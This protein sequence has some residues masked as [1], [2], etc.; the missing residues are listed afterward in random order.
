MRGSPRP[1]PAVGGA[2]DGALEH[3]P[4]ERDVVRHHG[5]RE[6]VVH[7]LAGLE[8]GIELVVAILG[9]HLHQGWDTWVSWGGG[10]GTDVISLDAG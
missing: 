1:D 8:N 4:L 6:V 5:C 9:D 10:V 7:A 3:S 2:V